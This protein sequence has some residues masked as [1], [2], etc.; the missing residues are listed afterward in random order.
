MESMKRR[1]KKLIMA[2]CVAAVMIGVMATP[3]Q[4]A[5]SVS[6]GPCVD[7][8]E[9]GKEYVIESVKWPGKV[10]APDTRAK[11]KGYITLAKFSTTNPR[12]K[13]QIWHFTNY[14]TRW[15]DTPWGDK[16]EES[17]TR[18]GK[19]QIS[20]FANGT[21]QQITYDKKKGYTVK[22]TEYN[23]DHSVK[24][25]QWFTGE[26]V[27]KQD[28]KQVW[29]I[30]GVSSGSGMAPGGWLEVYLHEPIETDPAQG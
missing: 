12:G 22:A 3:A 26:K 28:G 13:Q 29:A 10:A 4:A 11:Y 15:V 14:D 21:L 8:I 20:N 9:P 19:F 16:Y 24:D 23:S 18:Q 2:L 25:T 30:Y 6:L 7:E 17:Y 27:R 1:F 5:Y